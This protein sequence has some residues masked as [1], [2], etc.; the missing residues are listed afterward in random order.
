ME[1]ALHLSY[2]ARAD[3]LGSIPLRSTTI[4][5]AFGSPVWGTLEG[6]QPLF[7]DNPDRIRSQQSNQFDAALLKIPS[8]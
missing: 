8:R 6:L 7:A 3:Y 4:I 5:S 1:A 2:L